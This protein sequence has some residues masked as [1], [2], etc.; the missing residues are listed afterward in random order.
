[1]F[2]PANARMGRISALKGIPL[3]ECLYLAG[4]TVAYDEGTLIRSPP[5]VPAPLRPSKDSP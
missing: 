4:V 3:K 1:M 5:F 2:G